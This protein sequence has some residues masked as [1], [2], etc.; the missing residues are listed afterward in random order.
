MISLANPAGLWALLGIPAVLAI[1][2]L[3]RRAKTVPVTTLFLLEKTQRES[4]SGRRFDRLMG[5]VPL[6]MQLL[7]VLLLTWLLVEPRYQKARSTQRV[8]VVVDSSASMSVFKDA[9]IRA[10]AAE[11]PKLRGAA[12][13]IELTVRESAADGATL[14]SG[15]S[16]AEALESLRGWSPRDG[17]T[18]P[19]AALR[20]AR[21]VVGRE[22]VVVLAT[23]APV[24]D[25]PYD[26]RVLAVGEAVENVGVTGVRFER[27]EGALVWN[28]V[29]RNY[30]G[31]AAR[32]TWQLRF[33]DGEATEP[34]AVEIGPGAMVSLQAAF[35]AGRERAR[36][37]I[38]G[39]RFGLDDVV[40]LVPPRPKTLKLFAS[41]S[42][43]FDELAGRLLRS[44]EAVEASADAADADL[45][46]VSYDPLDP[47][48]PTGNAAVFVNDEVRAGAYLK[49]GIVAEDHPLVEGLNWQSLLVRE[50]LQLERRAGDDVLLWQGERPLIF[51]RRVVAEDGRGGPYRQLCFNFDLRRSNAPTQPA[52]IVCLHRFSEMIRSEKV[53]PV[54]AMLET[55]QPVELAAET[56]AGGGNLEVTH[57]DLDGG[58]RS[59]REIPAAARV[60]FRAPRE[61]GFLRVEQNGRRLLEAALVFGDSREADFSDR[62]AVND[63][64]RGGEARIERH[65]R[66]DH[67]WRLWVL[68]LL[69]AL[70]VSWHF[71]ASARAESVASPG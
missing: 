9:L 16:V 21:S 56:G 1:H 65:T 71:S 40:P 46:L 35:P 13:G 32:R 37:V 48:L 25:P 70:G 61:P 12:T 43:A 31:A 47:A 39:D 29:V 66:E 24:A 41:T 30:A 42:P 2:F 5:S 58:A 10:L 23:D 45:A 54:R 33:A 11:F 67:W 15:D 34:Q 68:L 3:Q 69:I 26:A 52:F 27:R 18:D 17:L 51:L 7:A 63:L 8:A 6:W 50:S 20:V 64:G 59:R 53:A 38:S 49:G 14:Y 22:G 60:S 4:A 55:G 36:L 19:S 44:L 28:A 62:G 57:F